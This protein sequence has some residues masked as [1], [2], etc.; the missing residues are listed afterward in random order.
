VKDAR[1][2]AKKIG[3]LA[4]NESVKLGV[5]RDGSQ[6]TVNVTLAT[7]PNEKQASA[8]DS[9]KSDGEPG[10]DVPKLGLSLAPAGSVAGVGG[11]GVVVTNVDPDG[12]A[13]ER[14]FKTGDV[15]VEVAG[16]A[17]SKPSDV[18][19]VLS[20]ARSEGKKTVLLRVKSG[21]VTRFVAL[22]VGSA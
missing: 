2:L 9:S 13:A 15:I 6:R 16:K 5:F 19:K 20:A 18:R 21:D 4:P 11:E 7:M 14:G 3:G 8:D 17:V 12:P 10:A 1:D 22:P